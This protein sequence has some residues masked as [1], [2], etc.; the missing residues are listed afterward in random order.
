MVKAAIRNSRLKV[1]NADLH[2]HTCLSPCASLDMTPIKIVN[3]AKKKNINLI[4]ICDHNSV[5]NVN[6]V[7]K[8]SKQNDI[9]VIAG[10]EVTTAE[11]IHV[12]GL[13]ENIDKAL[14]MQKLVYANLHQ[15]ENDENKFGLQVIAS[16]NDEVNGMNKRLLIGATKLTISQVVGAIHDRDG[17]AIA[18]HI[19]RE[20][21]GIIYQIG[22]IPE[23]LPLNGLE[24]TTMPTSL[25]R[26]KFPEYLNFPFIASSDAHYLEDIGK[27][28]TRFNIENSSLSEISMAL[29]NVNNRFIIQ[30]PE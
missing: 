20:A 13:F 22:F 8:A 9:E 11:E 10:I 21:F 15:G 14:S 27:N 17:I 3:K 23:D 29:K 1:I 4:A 18:S 12:I 30:G 2:I 16:E 24:T 5:E 6:A 25:A 19:D 26:Q 7:K 28:I